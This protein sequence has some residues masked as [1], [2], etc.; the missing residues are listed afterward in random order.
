VAAGI[1]RRAVAGVGGAESFL[2][3]R[4]LALSIRN[5]P[6]PDLVSADWPTVLPT[7]VADAFDEDLAR[8][9]DKHPLA[10]ALLTALAWARGPGLPW[11]TIWAP[12]ARAI[13]ELADGGAGPMI[14]DEGI[15]W[16]LAHAGAY[17]VE[18]IGPGKRSAYRPFHDLLAAHLRGEPT[19]EQREADPAAAA[20]WHERRTRTEA[21][22]TRALLGTVP[23][24]PDGEPD[25]LTAHP[26]LRTYLAQH[27]AAAG[28]EMFAS[29]TQDAGYLALADPVT[30]TPLVSP[31]DPD[32]RETARIYRR[33]LPLLGDNPS[34]NAAPLA[35][36]RLAI[37]GTSTPTENTSV[38]LLYR[39]RMASVSQDD[40]LLT[41]TGHAKAVYSVAFGTAPDGRLLLVTGSAEGTVRVWDPLTG[42]PLSD[43]QQC[44]EVN[45]AVHSEICAV[46]AERL[47]TERELLARCPRC[48]PVPGGW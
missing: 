31:A 17:I 22:I 30:L 33:A 23:S 14:G 12:T 43:H 3:A 6:E 19:I 47:V 38:H 28:T 4:L 27:A 34:A 18:D 20:A 25:W 46:P 1:A 41:L 11:E 32:L 35:E 39:T 45:A 26:Y 36:V 24:G 40:S 44:S 5:R 7:S 8:L 21:A 42:I 15:R 9:G 48:G 13:A 37:T 2:L 16:L 29:L 10:R